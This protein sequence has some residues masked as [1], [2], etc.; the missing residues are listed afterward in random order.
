MKKLYVKP[1]MDVMEFSPRD[2]IMNNA[3]SEECV[4]PAQYIVLD[5]DV[6]LNEEIANGCPILANLFN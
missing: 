6:D 1:E 2:M 5:G 4:A 3:S